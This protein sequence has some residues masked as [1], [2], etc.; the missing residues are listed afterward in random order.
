MFTEMINGIGRHDDNAGRR[1]NSAQKHEKYQPLH[2]ATSA[3]AHSYEAV[4]GSSD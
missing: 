3:R 2:D 1:N 4:Q